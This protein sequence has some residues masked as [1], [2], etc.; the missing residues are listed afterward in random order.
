MGRIMKT[1]KF[2]LVVLLATFFLGAACGDGPGGDQP[3]PH[4]I[5]APGVTITEVAIYQGPK[6]TIMSMGVAQTCDV[7]LINGRDA[8]IRVFYQ[9]DPSVVGR[10]VM[11]RF[12]IDAEHTYEVGVDLIAASTEENLGSTVNF[13][14]PGE[15]IN[16]FLTY[17][18]AFL[19]EGVDSENNPTAIFPAQG[20]Q[21]VTVDGII[22]TFR[23]IMA[24]FAYCADGSC[25]V[26]DLGPAVLE[27][28][29][30]RF[31]QLY[32]VTDV[33]VT[34]RAPHDWNSV[35]APNGDGWEQV[36][37]TLAGFR[38]QDGESADVY[39]YGIFNPAASF[40]AYCGGGC[41]LGVTLLNSSP[42]AE[43]N[44]QLRLALGVGF[45]EQAADTAAHEL[46][47]AHGLEHVNC[48]YGLDPN[49]IDYNYP[50]DPNSIGVWSWDIVNELLLDP[51]T[52]TDIM[53]YCEDTWISDYHYSKLYDRAAWVNLPRYIGSAPQ[54]SYRIVS[55][56][57]V[58]GGI[59]NNS[60]TRSSHEIKGQ[61]LE[62]LSHSADG[63][64]LVTGQF[65][66]WD[67]LP[68]GFVYVPEQKSPMERVE[69]TVRGVHTFAERRILP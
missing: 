27:G 55:V 8:L 63:T 25:R 67:H 54:F 23:V 19:Q 40:Y 37:M 41:M 65:F 15:A 1:A 61:P 32:P 50:H 42:P 59:I 18:I 43:G 7:P 52:K 62:V 46:G 51:D 56:D 66:R 11:G 16:Q 60:V 17:Q 3:Q 22:N 53:G 31:L 4:L 20:V 29:R 5:G 39:Y 28:F 57:G 24:P 14:V 36:G 10:T 26:P 68:G 13:V 21:T 47:H 45:E 12:S 64:R 48:G 58:G 33:E 49:S 44:P 35:I 69:L 9:A 2:R 30:Q 34:A 6:C 38:N